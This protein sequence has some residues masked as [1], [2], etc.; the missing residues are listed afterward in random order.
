VKASGGGKVVLNSNVTV[1]GEFDV[2]LTLE[3]AEGAKLTLSADE[4]IN[5]TGTIVN[6]GTISTAK[7]GIVNA[8]LV[9]NLK[10]FGGTFELTAAQ[11]SVTAS[12][13]LTIPANTTL[14]LSGTAA[15]TVETGA[16]LTV[17]SG[18]S[19]TGADSPEIVVEG[20]GRINGAGA[21]NFYY[22]DE[23]T[24]IAGTIP[25]G[26]YTWAT[27]ADGEGTPGWKSDADA[28]GE[29]GT[30]GDTPATV[31][32]TST[33]SEVEWDSDTNIVTIN[34]SGT[35]ALNGH[36]VPDGKALIIT[37]EA[38]I[39]NQA[40]A[41]NKTGTGTITNNGTINT[42]TG[43]I[44]ADIFANLVGLEGSGKVVLKG[45]VTAAVDITLTQNLEIA[46]S[47]GVL[48]LG[49]HTISPTTKITKNDGMI[50]TTTG[51]EET[52]R[53]LVGLA[54][55]GEVEWDNNG[56]ITLT[57]DALELTTQDLTIGANATL[58]LVSLALT[59]SGTGSITNNGTIKTAATTK[60]ALEAI[61]AFHGTIEIGDFTVVGA[62]AAETL[63]VPAG[64]KLTVPNNVTLTLGSGD[65]AGTLNLTDPSSKLVLKEGGKVSAANTGST[66]IKVSSSEAGVT[67]SATT[68]AD[69]PTGVK[70]T[71]SNN[72]DTVWV[73][74]VDAS[75]ESATV[76]IG[77]FKLVTGSSPL[78]DIAGDTDGGAAGSL[79][80]G[81]G[82]TIT[83]AGKNE[84]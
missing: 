13:P 63:T 35:G 20:T 38:I 62:D 7:T 40:E 84:V 27:D 24:P 42:G 61:L 17:A 33:A 29:T 80:A 70:D 77:K 28:P 55:E 59:T 79:E 31:R 8:M 32:N 51:T 14:K 5:G 10:Q 4:Q 36:T 37:S 6:H 11:I 67:V 73:L 16:T 3:I 43:D 26:T 23:E 52:L 82:T 68:T 66:I 48:T 25:A 83:F 49:A 58:D 76:I 45:R 12:D 41:I 78:T 75:P 34:Y 74:T 69:A 65:Y 2:N 47:T 15:L 1:S 53:N 71:D 30:P 18:A 46:A 54:G 50:K 21:T 56:T 57:D 39:A 60:A 22:N 81:T 44:G 19:I 64:T 72:E 9:D